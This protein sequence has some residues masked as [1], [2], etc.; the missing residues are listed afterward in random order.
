MSFVFVLD[1]Q[2]RPLDPVHPGHARRLLAQGRAAVW[3]RYPFTLILNIARPDAAPTPLRLKIDPG[4]RITGLTLVSES[5]PAAVQAHYAA[6]GG[7][8]TAPGP[9]PADEGRVVWAGELMH[10]GHAV[11]ER[12]MARA[13]VRR[14]RRARH[15]RYRPSRF[16]NRRRPDGWLPPSLESR[17][18]NVETWV[19]RLCRLAPVTALAQE[20]VKFDTQ[21]LVNPELT[22]V[23]YQQ[24]TLAGYELREYLLEKW[25]RC[26]AYC[27]ATGVPLQVEHIVPRSRGGS[28]RASNLTLACGICNQKKGAT[29]AEE[30][31]HPEVQA[32]ARRPLRDAAAVN[33]TRWALYQ[34]LRATGLAVESGTGGRTKWNRTRRNLP[35][36]HW[37]DAACVAASTPQRLTVAGVRPLGITA[38][39]HGNRQLCGTDKYGFPARHRTR[40]KRFFGFQT[41]DLVR[42]EVPPGF[43]TVGR[44]VGRVLV[45]AS[46]SFDVATVAGRVAGIGHRYVRAL[47]RGDGYAYGYGASGG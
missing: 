9:A 43:K 45:R 14:S 28:N 18:A 39:G 35:K 30:F 22:G 23:E 1:T 47:A 44:H 15:T 3:C 29:T 31:G 11:H 41:G 33:A 20:L 6:G 10:R 46:G 26:C 40:H 7:V 36:A 32:Q 13:A 34:R 16:D 8:P 17:L 37:L 21:A 42:A 19:R 27:K 5:V 4:S 25:G 12:L 2:Q 24:G 38:T